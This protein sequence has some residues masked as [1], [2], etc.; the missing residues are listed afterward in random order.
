MHQLMAKLITQENVEAL[1]FVDWS[2][3]RDV[4]ETAFSTQD[5]V[6]LLSAFGIAQWVVLGKRFGIPKAV[7]PDW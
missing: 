3:T 1:G 5:R 2:R 7:E 4:V 6:A